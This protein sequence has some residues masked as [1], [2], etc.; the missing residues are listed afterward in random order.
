MRQRGGIFTFEFAVL[1]LVGVL[2]GTLIGFLV[3]GS[4]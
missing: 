1:A 4:Q 3:F 2:I